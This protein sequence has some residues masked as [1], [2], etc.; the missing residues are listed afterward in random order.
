LAHFDMF[1]EARRS[2]SA[3]VAGLLWLA[4]VLG[5]PDLAHIPIQR[6]LRQIYAATWSDSRAHSLWTRWRRGLAIV[7]L[8]LLLFPMAR[9]IVTIVECYSIHHDY[10][11]LIRRGLQRD[12][13]AMEDGILPALVLSPWRKEAQILFEQYAYGHRVRHDMNEFREVIWKFAQCEELKTAVTIAPLPDHLPVSLS[14]P[15]EVLNDPVVWYTSIIV[16]AEGVHESKMLETAVSILERRKTGEAEIQLAN[17]DLELN[18]E[19]DAEDAVVKQKADQLANV[20]KESSD[21]YV[22]THV[23]QAGCD[24]LAGYYLS[25]CDKDKAAYWYERELDAR[26]GN[27]D[28]KIRWHRPPGKLMLYHM[29]ALRGGSWRY[30]QAEAINWARCLLNNKECEDS[31][32]DCDFRREF[33]NIIKKYE[34]FTKPEEWEKGAIPPD[35]DLSPYF[36]EMLGTG[37]RY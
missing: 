5:I 30:S 27:R 23:F 21:K 1:D 33:A 24:T 22:G 9:A 29:F 7:A 35:K 11:R 13:R 26:R 10:T 6:K 25:C 8:L 3:V 37:W 12:P 32:G 31:Q 17:F 16:E 36:E 34:D 18:S 15:S 14:G 4:G 28:D 19:Q 20:L 2:Y